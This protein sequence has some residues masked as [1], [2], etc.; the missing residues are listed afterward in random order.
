MAVSLWG[1]GERLCGVGT[2]VVAAQ[3]GAGEP[4]PLAS[5]YTPHTYLLSIL[6]AP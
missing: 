5:G 2:P 3:P 4:Q 1:R 6:P